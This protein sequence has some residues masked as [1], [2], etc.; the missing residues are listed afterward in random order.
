MEHNYVNNIG[1][2][3]RGYAVTNGFIP[4]ISVKSNVKL[5]R[6]DGITKETAYELG[7]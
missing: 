4:V 3:V 7:I 1:T 6:G 5:T 2:L